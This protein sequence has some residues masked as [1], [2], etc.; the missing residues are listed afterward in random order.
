MMSVLFSRPSFA[1]FV[2]LSPLLLGLVVAFWGAPEVRGQAQKKEKLKA[3]EPKDL[4]LD[5]KD[6]V[7]LH[8]TYYQGGAVLTG[9]EP[10]KEEYVARPG[11]EVVP[12]IL[13]HGF[14]GNRGLYEPFAKYLQQLGHAVIV[15]DL[16]GHGQS[17]VRKLPG[18]RS[19]EVTTKDMRNND[20]ETMLYDLLA[21]KKF[22]LAENNEERL[23]IELLCIV[24]SDMGATLAMNYAVYDWLRPSLPAVKLGQ[25]VKALVLISPESTFKGLKTT[26]VFQHPVVRS[27]LSVMI[28]VGE[29]DRKALNEAK[30]IYDRLKRYHAPIPES[31]DEQRQ[32]QDLFW[33]PIKTSLQGTKLLGERGLPPLHQFIANFINMRLVE[34]KDMLGWNKRENPLSDD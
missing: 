16:R 15:P 2:R 9:G 33:I 22:L 3:A 30:T 28:A 20:Y 10:G 34:K 17:T 23:N 25:D 14:E 11:R 12:V 8:C 29:D 13:L 31:P 1:R 27:T 24:G 4:T 19:V 18:G 7:E 32:K 5:T 6:G 26:G 21:I